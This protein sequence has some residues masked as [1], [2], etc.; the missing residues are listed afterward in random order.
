MLFWSVQVPSLVF[1]LVFLR[2]GG[3]ELMSKLEWARRR[4][5]ILV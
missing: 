1:R 3:E 2:Q 4:A 5:C